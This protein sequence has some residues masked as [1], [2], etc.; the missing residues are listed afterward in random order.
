MLGNMNKSGGS[1]AQ[2]DLAQL[3]QVISNAGEFSQRLQQLSQA[4]VAANE[5]REKLTQAED[6]IEATALAEAKQKELDLLIAENRTAVNAKIAEGNSIKTKII[7]KAKDDA[8]V[9][10]AQAENLRKAALKQ[11]EEANELKR[12]AEESKAAI[13]KKLELANKVYAEAASLKKEFFNKTNAFKK[14]IQ[15]LGG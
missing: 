5:A 8:K 13:D 1:A 12:E 3:L 15:E 14:F 6:L 11:A 7:A 10:V 4:E 2:K 9:I